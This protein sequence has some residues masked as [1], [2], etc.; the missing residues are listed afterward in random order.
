M[1]TDGWMGFM[2]MGMDG[3]HGNGN[4]WER[5]DGWDSWE[6]EW[7]GTDGWIHG[8]G[9]MGMGISNGWGMRHWSERYGE[10]LMAN[11]LVA[12]VC[13]QNMR[14]DILYYITV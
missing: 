2:G 8:M 6:W 5:M 3:I 13:G 7:M 14:Q 10:L 4:G 9:C 11:H 12:H 1:G